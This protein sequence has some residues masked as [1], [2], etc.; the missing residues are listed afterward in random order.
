MESVE[1]QDRE[2]RRKRS[3]LLG[4]FITLMVIAIVVVGVF[5]VTRPKTDE[6]QRSDL[7]V[8]KLGPDGM[9]V[10]GV[11]VPVRQLEQKFTKDIKRVRAYLDKHTNGY[12]IRLLSLALTGGNINEAEFVDA[13]GKN[14][15]TVHF[16]T[17]VE[18][19]P[20]DI[21][22]VGL[23]WCQ[24]DKCDPPNPAQHPTR[25]RGEPFEEYI[26]KY[27][28]GAV[29]LKIDKTIYKRIKGPG[30]DM[31]P[32]YRLLEAY[33]K[34][35]LSGI[36][37]DVKPTVSIDAREAVP[38]EHVLH[39]INAVKQ[40]GMKKIYFETIENSEFMGPAFYIVNE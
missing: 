28:S 8:V 15:F 23:Y 38:W 29:A 12:Y 32:D 30:G 3:R 31:Q 24:K 25:Y 17:E 11:K 13:E 16:T 14:G 20:R 22:H 26:K 21:L 39:A 35:K 27:D 6:E 2:E 34:A 36:P 19:F 5:T 7:I 18:S 4:V 9:Y 33:I 1:K 37:K 10:D 40:P